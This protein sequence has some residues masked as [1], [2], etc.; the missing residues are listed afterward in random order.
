MTIDARAAG[1]GVESGGGKGVG[2]V[3]GGWAM[4]QL[5]RSGKRRSVT[6]TGKTNEK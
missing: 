2:G 5:G 3:G 1:G 4:W 6:L